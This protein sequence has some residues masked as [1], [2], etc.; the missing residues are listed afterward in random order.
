MFAGIIFFFQTHVPRRAVAVET[1]VS[2]LI[3]DQRDLVTINVSPVCYNFVSGFFEKIHSHAQTNTHWI[4]LTRRKL[5]T[6][7]R[8]GRTCTNS[9][10]IVRHVM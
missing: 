2:L 7:R 10:T 8:P 5:T 6:A 9:S 4:L 1:F 3:I